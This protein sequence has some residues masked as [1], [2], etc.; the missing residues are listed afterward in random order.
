M[1]VINKYVL[2]EY[3]NRI[4]M[5][6][7]PYHHLVDATG[8]ACPMPLLKAKQALRYMADGE[9]LK[10]IATDGGSVR[11]VSVFVEHSPHE[12]LGMSEIDACYT[13][14]IKKNNV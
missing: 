4:V 14:F 13:Y 9:V 6:E 10:V 8:L 3:E 7:I 11:D 5:S 12:M 2:H 1:F